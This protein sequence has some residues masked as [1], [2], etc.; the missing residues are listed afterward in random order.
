MKIYLAPHPHPPTNATPLCTDFEISLHYYDIVAGVRVRLD[1]QLV[2]AQLG[3]GRQLGPEVHRNSGR[4]VRQ[5][6]D[7]VQRQAPHSD[8]PRGAWHV[9]RPVAGHDRQLDFVQGVQPG[10][11]HHVPVDRPHPADRAELR[12]F[13]GRSAAVVAHRSA[14]FRPGEHPAVRPRKPV[15]EREETE[16]QAGAG[17]PATRQVAHIDA[18]LLR[19]HHQRRGLRSVQ[20]LVPAES[21]ADTGDGAAR[22][23]VIAAS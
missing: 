7:P 19:A 11:P 20:I 18:V 3:S 21:R 13:G 23:T 8:T 1:G 4:A 15:E 9:L 10:V 22:C 6:G 17:P 5:R 14:H 12:L 16:T 2:R